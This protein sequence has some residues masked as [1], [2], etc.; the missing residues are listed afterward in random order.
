MVAKE[1]IYVIRDRLIE[2]TSLA[3]A[4]SFVAKDITGRLASQND[5]VEMVA[6]GVKVE[7]V[8]N[9]GAAA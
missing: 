5:L 1:R 8:D 4:K 3:R 2:A 6:K 9:K 7:K